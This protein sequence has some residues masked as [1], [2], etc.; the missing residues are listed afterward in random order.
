MPRKTAR[1]RRSPRPSR[2]LLWTFCM[3]GAVVLVLAAV[4]FVRPDLVPG[5]AA[6]SGRFWV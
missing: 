1:P 2:V 6:S 4:L 3:G 5:T